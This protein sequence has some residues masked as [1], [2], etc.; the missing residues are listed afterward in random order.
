MEKISPLKAIRNKC[1]DCC[2]GQQLE[3]KLCPAEDC[4]IYLFRFGKNP[5]SNR[6]KN[7]TEEQKAKLR[8]RLKTA[9]E[10][11]INKEITKN[12]QE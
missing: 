12:E 10:N 2:F 1:L 4:P 3:V 6:T 5:F 7:M 8:E 9:R 11:K